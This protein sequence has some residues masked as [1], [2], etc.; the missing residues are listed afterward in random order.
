MSST[1]YW[2]TLLAVAPSAMQKIPKHSHGTYISYLKIMQSS[3]RKPSCRVCSKHV[4]PPF[5]LIILP[6]LSFLL[7]LWINE[8]YGHFLSFN[9]NFQ[10]YSSKI[11]SLKRYFLSKY[12]FPLLL[13]ISHVSTVSMF[14]KFD[15]LFN[16]SNGNLFSYI[17][18]D[19]TAILSI[20]VSQYSL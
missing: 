2:S 15:T 11:P 13:F 8:V 18:S 4:F 16:L 5:A 12:S 3:F 10:W 14:T 1:D 20:K 19:I 17:S 6:S 7:C 9:F